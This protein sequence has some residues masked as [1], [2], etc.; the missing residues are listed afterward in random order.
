M[1][2][3]LEMLVVSTMLLLSGASEARAESDWWIAFGSFRDGHF[4]GALYAVSTDGA[5][6]VT[7]WRREGGRPPVL[8]PWV[9]LDGTLAVFARGGG[10]HRTSAWMV[11]LAQAEERRLSSEI[12]TRF[13]DGAI[14]P[15]ARP[16]ASTFVMVAKR[17]GEL[18][19]ELRSGLEGEPSD[20]GKGELPS[21]SPDGNRLAVVRRD[22]TER[23]VWVL[24]LEGDQVASEAL[25]VANG[26]Y[27]SWSQDGESLLVSRDLENQYD[28]FSV[29][30]ES[31]QERRLTDTNERSERAAVWSPDG[32]SIA[33]VALAP[34]ASGHQR[35]IFLLD[36]T[37]G[38]AQQLTSGRF[39]EMRPTWTTVSPERH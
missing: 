28:L 34:D 12:I 26:S 4:A 35:S 30:L 7:L 14:W 3:V 29:N 16:G 15:S 8:D 19:I 32:T 20:L 24:S 36:P 18:R 33:Y 11:D 10:S 23:S 17:A 39:H 37:S 31:G 21:W 6:E 2:D 1:R 25:V 13:G 5:E 9:S 22:G 27:P 38:D